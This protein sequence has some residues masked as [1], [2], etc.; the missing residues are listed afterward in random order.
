M[1]LDD[2]KLIERDRCMYRQA[3][4]L[5]NPLSAKSQNPCREP[6]FCELYGYTVVQYRKA[7]GDTITKLS[8]QGDD[9]IMF[10]GLVESPEKGTTKAAG[11]AQ[12]ITHMT[13]TYPSSVYW[14][15]LLPRVQRELKVV[16]QSKCTPAS[17]TTHEIDIL[18]S[19]H[20]VGQTN[21]QSP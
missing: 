16:E 21:N 14:K 13:R 2:Y 12:F 5:E 7:G 1:I 11:F 18:E 9:L 15:E 4:P 20:N 17:V 3:Y 10:R 19:T 6:A 8:L